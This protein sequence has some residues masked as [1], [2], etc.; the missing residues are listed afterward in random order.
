M[1]KPLVIVALAAVALS[2]WTAFYLFSR[3]PARAPSVS[4]PT[5]IVR[6]LPTPEALIAE[7]ATATESLNRDERTVSEP[8]PYL[9]PP[10]IDLTGRTLGRQRVPGIE[11][12]GDVGKIYFHAPSQTL[13]MAVTEASGLRS[14]WKLVENGKIER[15]FAVSAS[16]GE[17]RIDGDSNGVIYVQHDNPS[18]LFRSDDGLK[19]WKEVLNNFGM[20]WSIADDGNGTLYGTVHDWNTA[21]LY[22]SNDN[23]LTWAPWIDFQKLFPQYAQRYD[24]HDGRFLLRHLHGVIYDRNKHRLIVGTG[25]IARFALASDDD[26]ASW[27]QVW[28]EGFTA[29]APMSGGFRWLLGPDQL[30]GHGLA[31]YDAATDETREVW[32]PI[33]RNYAGYV[34]SL[35]N[36]NGIYYAGFHT[37]ANEVDSL[38]P[39]FGIIVS[40]D[41]VAWYPFLEWGPLS[42]HARTNVWLTSGSNVV[43]ASVNGALYAFRPL[44]AAWFADKTSF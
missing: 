44:D 22:R 9:P 21:V 8:V 38:V 29:A 6:P 32:N 27:R 3:V 23:G 25:D 19:N 7:S 33:P 26:G 5:R 43:Y 40:P 39:K 35:L 4:S 10:T 42:N 1:R 14:V 18:R 34:Y 36:V 16:A 17:I 28:D 2:A 37:E 30:H 20:F 24:P 31:I 13:F 15:V 12:A 11:K 41:G